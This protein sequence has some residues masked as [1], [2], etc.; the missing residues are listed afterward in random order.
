[1][2][3]PLSNQ[4]RTWGMISH[5]SAFAFFIF[6]FGHIFGPLIVWLIK[7]DE[8][9]FVNEQAKEALNF[10]ISITI[11]SIISGILVIVLIGIVMLIVLVILDIVLVIMAS[12]KAN[13]GIG[14]R[15]PFSIRVIK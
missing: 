2:Y 4:E 13:D 8:F 15:Y 10:Q 12:I 1:M 3:E 7:K 11:Y 5:L 14:F 6:P 9:S